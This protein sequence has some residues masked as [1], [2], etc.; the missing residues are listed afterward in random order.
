MSVLGAYI[1]PDMWNALLKLHGK[2]VVY[3][4]NDIETVTD[5]TIIEQVKKLVAEVL[6]E[7]NK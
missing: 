6:A 5:K 3:K 2:L 7:V 4:G 1:Q